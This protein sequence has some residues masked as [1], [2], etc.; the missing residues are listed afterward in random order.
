MHNMCGWHICHAECA[1]LNSLRQMSK[2]SHGGQKSIVLDIRLSQF[3]FCCFQK[4][5]LISGAARIGEAMRKTKK[6][7][8]E[9]GEFIMMTSYS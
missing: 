5:T 4:E 9:T 2:S 1:L 8:V 3:S 7:T 6:M